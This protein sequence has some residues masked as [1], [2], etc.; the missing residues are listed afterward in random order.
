[1][2]LSE[3]PESTCTRHSTNQKLL[4]MSEA[5]PGEHLCND[6]QGNHSHYNPKNCTVC[7]LQADLDDALARAEAAEARELKATDAFGEI[8]EIDN[9]VEL[10]VGDNGIPVGALL[11]IR[12]IA[13]V[14][15]NQDHVEL[16]CEDTHDGTP[17]TVNPTDVSL[18]TL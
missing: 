15:A 10:L 8:L 13:L 2:M 12:D 9:P 4:A 14:G 5:L 1:M 6:H 3:K 16:I 11:I 18:K 17:L 7:R